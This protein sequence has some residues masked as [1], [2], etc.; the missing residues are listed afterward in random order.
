MPKYYAIYE[1]TK[2]GE[3]IWYFDSYNGR[4]KQELKKLFPY[5]LKKDKT[6]SIHEVKI[7]KVKKV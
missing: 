3:E 5:C 2:R 6:L 4:T 7:I 1:K